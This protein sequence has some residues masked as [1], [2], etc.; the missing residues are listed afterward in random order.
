[1]AKKEES[2]RIVL[3]VSAPNDTTI[4]SG[5]NAPMRIMASSSPYALYGITKTLAP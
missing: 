5:L 3:N 1:M 4:A 2:R